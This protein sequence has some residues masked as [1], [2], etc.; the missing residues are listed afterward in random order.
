MKNRFP[1]CFP[2]RIHQRMK[3]GAPQSQIGQPMPTFAD[4]LPRLFLDRLSHRALV[5]AAFL[6]PA[7]QGVLG[8]ACG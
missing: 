5:T 6:R 4:D 3:E 1:H 7:R 2:R 8:V